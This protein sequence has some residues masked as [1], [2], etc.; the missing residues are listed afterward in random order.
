MSQYGKPWDV[1][2]RIAQS[3]FSHTLTSTTPSVIL[4]LTPITVV[5]AS[6]IP[7]LAIWFLTSPMV[8]WI[9]LD[10]PKGLQ[11]QGQQK[12]EQYLQQRLTPD[13][14]VAITTMGALAK[15]RASRVRLRD[16]RS[17]RRRLGLVNYVRDASAENARRKWYQF[18]AVEHF[19]IMDEGTDAAGQPWKWYAIMKAFRKRVPKESSQEKASR[20][21]S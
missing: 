11:R 15:P 6:T 2:I 14:Q 13:T 21:T 4:S 19:K 5:V 7:F 3:S 1:S 10:I 8:M 20:P 17:E 18:R 12:L 16:L 9:H